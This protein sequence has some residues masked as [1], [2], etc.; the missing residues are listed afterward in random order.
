MSSESG[1]AVAVASLSKCYRLYDRPQDRL[2]QGFLR[3]KKYFREFWALR[4]VTFSVQRGETVGIVGLNGSGKSTLLQMIAGTLNPTSGSIDVRGRVAALLEL[5]TGFNPDFTGRE[6]VYVNG[7][8]LGL[9]RAEIDAHLDEIIDFA[10]IGQFIDQPVR[11]YSSGMVVRLAFAVQ[12]VLPKDILI[13]DEV[14]AVGDEAFQR[15][16][17]FKI[18]AF[19]ERGGTVLFVSHNAQLVVQLCDRAILLDSGELLLQ[20]RSKPLVHRYQLLANAPTE[21]RSE[22]RKELEELGARPGWDDD[23]DAELAEIESSTNLGSTETSEPTE[24]GAYNP[25]LVNRNPVRYP[26]RGARIEDPHLTDLEGRRVNVLVNGNTYVYRYDI[27]FARIFQGRSLR[28][29]GQDHFR[30]RARR[31][32][33]GATGRWNLSSR[34]R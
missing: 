25:D 17:F 28:Y 10:Q 27:V 4:D 22:L 30:A 29:V 15:K 20:G 23:Q 11:T 24:S 2:K 33:V 31:A 18:D 16:C 3:R 34:G 13:V 5:G 21:L 6:N 19:R 14:L 12:S 26:S 7:S 1:V 32:T 8:I 9:P